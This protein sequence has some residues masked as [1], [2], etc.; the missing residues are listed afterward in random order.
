MDRDP[1][2]GL[3]LL[4]I[5]AAGAAACAASARQAN[6]RQK[7]DEASAARPPADV[8]P[9]VVRF[10]NDRGYELVGKDRELA[11]LSPQSAIRHAMA[12]GYETRIG[13]DG[14]RTLETNPSIEGVRIRAEGRA[15][16]G[17]R[18]RVF[19]TALRRDDL[20]ITDEKASRDLQLE[21]ALLERLDPVAAAA[22]E[23]APAAAAAPAPA[24]PW[25][26]VRHLVGTWESEGTAGP[27]PIRWTFDFTPGAQFLEVHGSSILGRP[28]AGP[29]PEMGRISRDGARGRLVWRQFTAGGQVN[30]YLLERSGGA[31][32]VFVTESAESLPPGSRAR[33]TL[34]GAAPDEILAVFEIA[35][36]G[37]DFAVVGESRIRRIR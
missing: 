12:L 14:S 36:P 31:A 16:P 22:L 30:Q 19:L 17:E 23:G 13:K 5:L 35:E 27:G 20:N 37:K 18:C 21:L 4:L 8:W 3:V 25:G 15:L 34:G 24:D 6:L 7:L 26:P 29:E 10:L 33:L 9:E 2:K 32:L 1:G 28:G 11:R